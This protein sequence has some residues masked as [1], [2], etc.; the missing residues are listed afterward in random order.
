MVVQK[1]HFGYDKM[2]HCYCVNGLL[3]SHCRKHASILFI[4]MHFMLMPLTFVCLDSIPAVFYKL[5]EKYFNEL[6]WCS[7]DPG[8]FLCSHMAA[9]GNLLPEALQIRTMALGRSNSSLLSVPFSWAQMA[10]ERGCLL[11]CRFEHALSTACWVPQLGKKQD[12]KTVGGGDAGA[13]LAPGVWSH[14]Q[15]KLGL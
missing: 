8:Q 13:S 1:V 2:F 4:E 5:H 3:W 10:L 12:R 7:P 11:F 15:S 9:L 14:S 6:G